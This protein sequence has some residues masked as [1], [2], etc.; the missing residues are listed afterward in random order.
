MLL[1][2]GVAVLLLCVMRLFPAVSGQMGLSWWL[3]KA[4]WC[5]LLGVPMTT[6]SVIQ[7]PVAFIA[8]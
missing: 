3:L 6:L 4:C 7:F 2:V 8:G 5:V 1:K